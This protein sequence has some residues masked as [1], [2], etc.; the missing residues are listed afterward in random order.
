MKNLQLAKFS[1]NK[2]LKDMTNRFNNWERLLKVIRRFDK[3]IN[4]FAMHIGLHRAENLYHIRKGNF[5]ISSDLADKIVNSDP[6]IDRTW[7]LSGVGAM[8]CSVNLRVA[9]NNLIRQVRRDTEVTLAN[10]I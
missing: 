2:K 7:L 6:E 4:S 10:M 1:Q 8:P 3:S 5:G 9:V